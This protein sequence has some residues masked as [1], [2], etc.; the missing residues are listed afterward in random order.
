MRKSLLSEQTAQL[1]HL[2]E[3]RQAAQIERTANAKKYQVGLTLFATL[4][5]T[6]FAMLVPGLF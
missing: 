5:L 4:G 2:E 3:T 6:L 1:A